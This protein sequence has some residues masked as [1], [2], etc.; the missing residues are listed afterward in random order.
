MLESISSELDSLF[1]EFQGASEE[2]EAAA[3]VASAVASSRGIE[4]A[5][6]VLPGCSGRKLGSR[7]VIRGSFS[8]LDD[9]LAQSPVYP[10]QKFRQIFRIPVKLYW[11]INSKLIDAEHRLA[12]HT[13]GL[14][15]PGHTSHQ[16]IIASLR[17]L[18]TGA[19]YRDI[20]DNAL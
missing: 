8:W 5:E 20:D 9:Y 4:V 18:G 3:I 2:E 17:R 6:A 16:K 19:S 13:D 7:S 12:Q 10:P 1:D 14:G 11:Y 15:R